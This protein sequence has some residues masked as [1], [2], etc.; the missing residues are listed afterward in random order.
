MAMMTRS[1][2]NGL[3]SVT[4]NRIGAEARGG[5][6][7]LRFTGKSQIAGPKGEVILSLEANAEGIAVIDI[8]VQKARDKS[9]TTMNDRFIDRR[10]ELY[11]II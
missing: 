7:E 3:Y 11:K 2:E 5:K 8:D 9:I 4:A 6:P 10:P 1:L